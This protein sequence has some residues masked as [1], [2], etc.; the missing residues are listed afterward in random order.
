MTYP[1]PY[2]QSLDQEVLTADPIHLVLLLLR[3]ARQ[4]AEEA[5]QALRRG[6]V[7]ERAQAVSRAVERIAEL[8]RN[9]DYARGGEIAGRM[10]QLYDYMIYR[11]NEANMQQTEAPLAEV[12]ELLMP[13]IEA[14]SEMESAAVGAPVQALECPGVAMDL[15]A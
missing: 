1:N 3:G 14:W 4:S 15:C 7:R 12:S 2:L 5:R 8:C 13:L 6:Q 9:L 11:L 10:A